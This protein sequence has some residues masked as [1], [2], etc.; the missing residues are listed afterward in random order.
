MHGHMNRYQI[1][2]LSLD[3]DRNGFSF[4][5]PWPV[6]GN[7]GGVRSFDTLDEWQAFIEGFSMHEGV[8]QIVSGRFQRAQKL[9]FLG[10]L[11]AGLIKAGEL[12]AL[13]ALELA[14]RDC[15]GG[16][17]KQGRALADRERP[18]MLRELLAFMVEKD[19]LTDGNIA[20]ALYGGTVAGSLYETTSARK[21]REARQ[22][23]PPT[24]IVEIRNSLAHGE[25]FGDMPWSGFLELMRD[26]I[27][28]AYRGRISEFTERAQP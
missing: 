21:E 12:V 10:W 27:H 3:A 2:H 22:A 28:Y 4:V 23:P 11:D 1:P 8:P 25:P 19:G 18:P 16:A 9:Y 6:P 20:F 7:L 26:L 24:N 17:I 15:Y 5:V 14:L 13:T